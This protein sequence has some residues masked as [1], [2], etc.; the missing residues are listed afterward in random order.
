MNFSHFLVERSYD[1]KNF[2]SIGRV[3]SV[4]AA[5]NDK[6]AY[7][8]V[9]SSPNFGLNYYRLRQVD[10][11]NSYEYSRIISVNMTK[12]SPIVI[13][14]NPSADYIRIKNGEEEAIKSYEIYNHSGRL[15]RQNKVTTNE[16]N[17]RDLPSGV[18][19]LQLTNA[20][21]VLINRMF[22]KI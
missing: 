20:R 3:N 17:I 4:S 14:P 8:F 16:I 2:E 18:Y 22:I 6:V 19:F 11:D 12:T 5:Y 10:I 21:N 9:D 1:A 7:Q 13:Y 15:I